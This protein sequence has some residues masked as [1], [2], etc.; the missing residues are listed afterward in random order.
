MLLLTS[1]ASK[2]EESEGLS[3]KAAAAELAG[4]SEAKLAAQ[5]DRTENVGGE[6]TAGVQR[7]YFYGEDPQKAAKVTAASPTEYVTLEG[8]EEKEKEKEEAEEVTVERSPYE[9]AEDSGPAKEPILEPIN[10]TPA[11]DS[12]GLHPIMGGSLATVDQMVSFYNSKA[13]YPSY[14]ASTDAPTIEDFC[15]I[16]LE[17]SEAE[18]I[19]AEVVFC[20]AM[21][22]S[23]WLKFGG[24]VSITQHNFAGLGATGG[25]VPGNSYDSVRTGIRAQVQHLKAYA[26][27]ADVSLNQPLVD[28]RFSYV[29]RGSAPY[30]EWLGIQENPSGGG[31]AASA[32][33]GYYITQNLMEP[34]LM[35]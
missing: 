31:W 3:V 18:G 11:T 25:G 22:E 27:S 26:T 35:Q 21:L 23:N 24:D 14:Y 5:A 28:D 8:E 34:L 17:E 12:T 4:E 10:G 15:R 33:Y 20:Q 9:V 30:V 7:D 19:K 6:K 29:V 16:C 32:N 2:Q 1:C 13:S